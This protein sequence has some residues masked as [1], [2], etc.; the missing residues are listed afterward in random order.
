LDALRDEAEHKGDSEAVGLGARRCRDAEGVTLPLVHIGYHK[1]GTNW[2]QEELFGDPR[3]GYRWLG[4]Q[5]LTHPVH[6]LVRARPFDFDPAAV[7]SEFEPMLAEAERDGLLPVVSFPRLS[8]HPYSGGYDS[9]QIADRI[10]QVFPEGRILVVIREQRSM[11]V[12][13]YKQYVNAGGEAKLGHFLQPSKQREWRVPG[14]DYGHFA[15][16]GLI[17]HYRSLYGADTVL[18]LPYEQFVADGP[19]FVEAIA[20]FAGREIPA[21]AIA[22][23]PFDVRSNKAQSALAIEVARPLN[24]FRRRSDLNPEP[25]FESRLLSKAG[26]RIRRADL[27]ASP[28]T[29]KLAR[30]SEQRLRDYVAAAVGTRYV[31]SNGETM[32]MTGLDLGALGWQV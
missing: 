2:L 5:P 32:R 22:R 16:D 19:G 13:T 3:T 26:T 1:T 14:F 27:L 11:I 8:G 18:V 21:D 12:S 25:L 17:G 28:A 6:T 30:G 7:R 23:L 4:K 31:P 15:Y 24:R 9:R 29:R 20:R 10:A